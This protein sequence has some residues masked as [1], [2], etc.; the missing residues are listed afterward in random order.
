MYGRLRWDEPAQT[1][2]TGFGSMGQGRYVHP[3]AA[4][5]LTPHEAA[6]IQS[7]PDFVDFGDGRRT[8]WAEMIGNAVPPLL[9]RE[10]GRLIVPALLS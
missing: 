4:R 2:T 5:T 1:I 10:I 3:R 9:A 8:E 7:I 6:R